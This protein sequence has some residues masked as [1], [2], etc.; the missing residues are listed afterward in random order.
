MPFT[1]FTILSFGDISKSPEQQ[2]EQLDSNSNN[3]TSKGRIMALDEDSSSTSTTTNASS[4]ISISPDRHNRCLK[5]ILS[6]TPN[7]TQP[8]RPPKFQ[9]AFEYRSLPFKTEDCKVNSTIYIDL[10]RA[11]MKYDHILLEPSNCKLNQ[12]IRID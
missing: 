7:P 6:P 4:T 9:Y 12:I 1:P 11:P 8:H 5:F 3:S 10:S 2:Q